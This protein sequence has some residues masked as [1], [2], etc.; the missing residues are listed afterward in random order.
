MFAGCHLCPVYRYNEANLRWEEIPVP[1]PQQQLQML[2]PARLLAAPP[3][4]NVPAGYRLRTFTGGDLEGYLALL[5]GAGFTGFTPESAAE[6]ARRT[7]PDGLF[8]IEHEET[9]APAASAM[10]THNP[11]ELHPNGG[12][13]GWVAGSAAHSGKG[14]G[15][16]V[17]MAVIRRYREAGY[18]RIYL[19]T[20]DWRLP[21][22][23]IYLKM[24]FAP[25]LFMWDMPERWRAA[26]EAL[27]RPYTPEEW[28]SVPYPPEP[29]E[30]R[31]DADR[32]DRYPP[33]RLWLPD[34]P[35]R[36]FAQRGDVAAFGDESLYHPSQLG[37]ATIEPSRVTAGET[38]PLCITFTAGPA[39]LPQGAKVTFLI[40]GQSPLGREF[41]GCTVEG[42][43]GRESEP[44]HLGFVLKEG[45]LAEGEIVV[46]TA[47]PFR[48]TPLANRKEFNVVINYG[49]N[50][51]EQRLPEP[52]VV[53][54]L[55]APPSRLEATVP[56]THAG[57]G[58]AVLVTLRDAFDNRALIDGMV[59]IDTEQGL[60]RFPLQDGLARG[61][62]SAGAIV[63]AQV[64][65]LNSKFDALSNPSVHSDDLHCFV[66]DL[67]CHDFMSEAEGYTDEVYRWALEDRGLD[68]VSVVPQT[69]GWLDNQTWTVAKYM[70][71][72]Y[73]K[74]G[75]F[76]TFLGFEWQHT[77]Y[78][79]KVVHYLG[80][81]Q[82]YL[83]VDDPR[84]SSPAK[85]YAA[86]RESDA[87]VITHTPCYP[88]GDWCGSTDFAAVETDVD[89][90]VEL[91]SM[92][93]SSEGWDPADRPLMEADPARQ[94]MPVLRRGIRMGFTAGSDT[95]SAR[96]G[97]SAKEPRP[98]WGGLTAIWAEE[99]TRRSL[100]RALRNRHT[101]ALTG[102]RIVL[103]FTVNGA[104]MGAE[105][106][107]AA[108]A[109]LRLDAWAPGEIAKVE[110]VKN[111]S[112]LREF[113]PGGDEC[114][115]QL[116][117]APGG[118]ACY[119]CRVTQA[120]GQLAVCSPVWVG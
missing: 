63:R 73:L 57:D 40:R 54:V 53:E 9:G 78:G 38:A 87:L 6:W 92:H 91:W 11:T 39:G 119:H 37:A 13:L 31:P 46:L 110:V 82:P 68:F 52:L 27:G 19:K 10:A 8:V 22:L 98:Y 67:H 97:G 80:G 61:F 42:P 76:V 21:A 62:T 106:P 1:A 51:P 115:L 60:R 33:R 108:A 69:H 18:R 26:C 29:P 120:D 113:T 66:G 85:L 23:K 50:A 16:A 41:P 72:R 59:I 96:P 14:L 43:A 79:D 71:E 117:D 17:C 100:F 103:K 48:W 118:P 45:A 102:A 93:G 49:G 20:D 104:L 5:H 112:L 64:E 55:P 58:T 7:L 114:H 15:M 32:P 95:H 116:E 44:A 30:E 75:E 90:L 4:V 89:R 2:W 56:C 77:G 99:L 94:V 101:V 35:H 3:A 81:D 24:G 109:D 47:A 34:R 83:P 105:I 111:A 107:V 65:L 70:N 12:E 36:G 88:E 86:L 74:E 25:F 84:Y 28:P